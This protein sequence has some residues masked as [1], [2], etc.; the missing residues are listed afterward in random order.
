MWWDVASICKIGALNTMWNNLRLFPDVW[1]LTLTTRAL[2]VEG[3]IHRSRSRYN[4]TILR[5]LKC[6]ILCLS[7][8]SRR[9]ICFR[10]DGTIFSLVIYRCSFWGTDINIVVS[11]EGLHILLSVLERYYFLGLIGFERT[12]RAATQEIWIEVRRPA[13]PNFLF[14][15]IMPDCTRQLN[16]ICRLA[17]LRILTWGHWVYSGIKSRLLNRH[18]P[19]LL[20]S[21]WIVRL[22]KLRRASTCIV[23]LWLP[24][25][26]ILLLN[27]LDSSCN[28]ALRLISF[29]S[30]IIQSCEGIIITL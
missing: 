18:L 25:I 3:L 7:S 4:C 30:S 10:D 29:L 14:W 19:N 16:T 5:L 6:H 17:R 13:I 23:Q 2:N 26:N 20:R 24:L 28:L 11:L 9:I 22:A 15:A 27:H 12:T 8:R 21:R 1:Y